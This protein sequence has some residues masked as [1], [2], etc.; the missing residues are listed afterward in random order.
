M[1]V[2]AV[3]WNDVG[4]LTALHFDLDLKLT[5]PK[6]AKHITFSTFLA[7]SVLHC[8]VLFYLTECFSIS[9]GNG[10]NSCLV[11]P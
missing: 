8:A 10:I 9:L 3:T 6:V 2:S 1:M 7:E 5:F 4:V 11:L